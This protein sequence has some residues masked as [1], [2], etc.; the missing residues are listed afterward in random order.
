M[1][2]SGAARRP[3]LVRKL[4]SAVIR[5]SWLWATAAGAALVA[6]RVPEGE[7]PW[8]LAGALI[9]WGDGRWWPPIR[10]PRLAIPVGA[11]GFGNSTPPLGAA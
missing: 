2:P 9:L 1:K 8:A 6:A 10:S 3:R 5:S 7:L 4:T 11:F